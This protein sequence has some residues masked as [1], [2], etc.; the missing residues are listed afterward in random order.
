MRWK[1][2]LKP[3]CKDAAGHKVTDGDAEQRGNQKERSV[4]TCGATEDATKKGARRAVGLRRL[5]SVSVWQP[6]F[7]LQM[8]NLTRCA[9]LPGHVRDESGFRSLAMVVRVGTASISPSTM[10][11]VS[12]ARGS[13]RLC[14]AGKWDAKE[15]K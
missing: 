2:C 5:F 10:P 13:D 3:T 4:T 15:A 7:S 1:V 6:P 9:N 11:T 8:M 14:S 12:G